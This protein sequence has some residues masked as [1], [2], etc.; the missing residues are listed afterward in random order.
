MHWPGTGFDASLQNVKSYRT[1]HPELKMQIESNRGLQRRIATLQHHRFFDENA[2]IPI[3][4]LLLKIK[5]N[6]ARL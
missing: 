4:Y 3:S 5:L 6:K 1:N 2:D